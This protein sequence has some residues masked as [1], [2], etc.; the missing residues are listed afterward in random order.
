[1]KKD[2]GGKES[3]VQKE[4]RPAMKTKLIK[5]MFTLTAITGWF[6]VLAVSGKAQSTYTITMQLSELSTNTPVTGATVVLNNETKLS[7]STG[8]VIFTVPAAN[9]LNCTVKYYYRITKEGYISVNDSVALKSNKQI[10]VIMK[11]ITYNVAF[12][13]SNGKTPILGARVDFN[14][15]TINTNAQGIA[16]FTGVKPAENLP[17]TVTRAQYRTV[18]GTVTVRGNMSVPVY[19]TLEGTNQVVFYVKN[20]ADESLLSNAVIVF[21]NDTLL[22]DAE[23]KAVFTGVKPD[24]SNNYSVYKN[25]F[26]EVT[27]SLIAST[28]LSRSILLDS[29]QI[30]FLVTDGN[31]QLENAEVTFNGEKR[32]TGSGGMA[33][34]RGVNSGQHLP[35]EVTLEGYYPRSG[36]IDVNRSSFMVTVVMI[37]KTTDTLLQNNE[38]GKEINIYPNPF[39]GDLYIDNDGMIKRVEVFNVLGKREIVMAPSAGSVIYLNTASLKAGMYL[40]KVTDSDNQ[41]HVFKMLKE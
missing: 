1:M 39:K 27:G 6:L 10:L 2:T 5:R 18:S 37:L 15:Q 32:K 21:N 36:N 29:L 13:V 31:R 34:F 14:S 28:D 17:Y 20:R 3:Q 35:Y 22:T 33:V 11:P 41:T 8:K 9:C 7:D 30:S 19:M 40:I 26:N 25:S 24:V 4:R 12:M 16:E 23:G 38:P